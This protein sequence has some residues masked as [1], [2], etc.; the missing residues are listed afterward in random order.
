MARMT[1]R[2]FLVCS[3]AIPVGCAIDHGGS[4]APS[5]TVREPLVGQSWRYA[6]HDFFTKA[7]VDTQDDEVTSVDHTVE[8]TSRTES[9][10]PDARTSN[11]GLTWLRKYFSRPHVGKR[12][13][14][15]LQDP[16]GKV[17]VDPHWGQVQ[18][19]DTPIPLWP[20][21]LQPGWYARINVKYKTSDEAGLP[22]DQTMKADR[23]ETVTVPAG[24]FRAL[25]YTNVINFTSSDLSRANSIRRETV[26]LAPEVGRWIARES[27]GTYYLD[28]STADDR[29]NESS[30]RWEL[31]SWS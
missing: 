3:A 14:S 21:R 28:E 17:V 2:F 9:E 15:E 4:A 7:Q 22:W 20:A 8:I 27:T 25:R 11:G 31:L 26:W 23:W 30:Y 5:P 16:W 18:V 1:R 29:N 13:P 10:T 6:K 19:Y 24:Q 12:L